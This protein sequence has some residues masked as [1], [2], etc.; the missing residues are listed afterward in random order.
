MFPTAVRCVRT[1]GFIRFGRT[2]ASDAVGRN[3]RTNVKDAVLADALTTNI[4]A[5]TTDTKIER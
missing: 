3:E 5:Y 2:D 4:H 1:Y